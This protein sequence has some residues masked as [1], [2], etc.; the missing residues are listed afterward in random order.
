MDLTI[1]APGRHS[2][3]LFLKIKTCS[4]DTSKFFAQG[5]SLKH[6]CIAKGRGA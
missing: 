3:A 1:A 6:G 5:F 2:I 4:A